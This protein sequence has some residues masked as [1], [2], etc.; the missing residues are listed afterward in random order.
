VA[1]YILWLVDQ[2]SPIDD[3]IATIP[4][5]TAFPILLIRARLKLDAKDPFRLYVGD[6]SME[7]S[8]VTGRVEGAGKLATSDVHGGGGVIRG[9]SVTTGAFGMCTVAVA[10]GSSSP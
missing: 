10:V 8:H 2:A 6:N 9:S 1:A 5:A 3:A 4:L 7:L